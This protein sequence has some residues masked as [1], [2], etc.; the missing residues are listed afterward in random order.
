MANRFAKVFP[1]QQYFD[2]N[3][4]SAVLSG[5]WKGVGEDPY[6]RFT[7]G[8]FSDESE[9]SL[10]PGAPVTLHQVH[11]YNPRKMEWVTHDLGDPQH[12]T[13]GKKNKKK[14]DKAPKPPKPPRFYRDWKG[15][16]PMWFG[17]EDGDHQ[18]H[19]EIFENSPTKQLYQ[20]LRNDNTFAQQ[21]QEHMRGLSGR[22][23][24]GFLR[25]AYPDVMD[26]LGDL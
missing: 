17:T 19:E 3:R 11:V 23:L 12:H 25:Q 18:N 5:R 10:L 14:K 4:L 22:E 9:I 1:N 16:H 2:P 7:D 15:P 21:Y 26:L 8:D 6:R 24:I 13:A 20:L